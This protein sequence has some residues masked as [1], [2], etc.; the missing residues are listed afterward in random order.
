MGEKVKPA[1]KKRK[2]TAPIKRVACPPEYLC[3]LCKGMYDNPCIARCCGRS[4]CFNCFEVQPDEVYCPLC[5]KAFTDD[6]T[7]IPNRSLFETVE[8]LNLDYFDVPGNKVPQ[9][10]EGPEVVDLDPDE[11]VAAPV[12]EPQ[13]VELPPT[14]VSVMPG[15]GLPP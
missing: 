2:E 13:K 8:S 5:S 9:S 1:R 6:N 11:V 3:P 10:V 15:P 4:A 12:K 7:P 14:S